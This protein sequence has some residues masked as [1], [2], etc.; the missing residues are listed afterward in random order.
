MYFELVKGDKLMSNV[1]DGV[2]L[3]LEKKFQRDCNE[4]LTFDIC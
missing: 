1:Q 4:E 3:D 2:F